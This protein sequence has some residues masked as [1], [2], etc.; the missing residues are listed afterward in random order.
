[1]IWYGHLREVKRLG[2][3]QELFHETTAVWWNKTSLR[4]ALICLWTHSS[5]LHILHLQNEMKGEDD[6][7]P[8]TVYQCL[9]C[10]NLEQP[11]NNLGT[12]C[13]GPHTIGTY[14]SVACAS[15]TC[16]WWACPGAKCSAG[17]LESRH[18][19]KRL[20]RESNVFCFFYYYLNLV[21]WFWELG[22]GAICMRT[23]SSGL[24]MQSQ[25]KFR[26]LDRSEVPPIACA[27][28]FVASSCG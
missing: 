5:C 16:G 13:Q 23:F 1:M 19:S 18:I 26:M 4:Q 20:C 9:S 28:V 6:L 27:K 21:H 10:L 24:W 8:L 11:W 22:L 3:V 12:T 17:S 14:A 2:V 15:S 7:A 25:E